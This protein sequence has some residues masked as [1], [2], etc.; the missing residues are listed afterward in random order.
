VSLLIGTS[1][2]QYDDWRGRFYPHGTPTA[3][4]LEHYAASFCTVEVNNTFYRLPAAS[5]FDGWA[6]RTP[7]DFRFVVKAS[8]YLTHQ[9]RLEDPGPSVDLLMDRAKGL[10]PKLGPVLL[11]LPP[12]LGVAGDRLDV[13]LA[14]FGRR[15]VRVAVEFRHDSWFCEEVYAVLRDHDAALCLTDRRSHIGPLVRTASWGYVRLHEG[16]AS[17]RPCYGRAALRSWV[18]RIS[19]LY[20]VG[21]DV[22][23]FTN[24]DHGGCAVRDARVLAG[25]AE[26]VG[27]KP[28]RVPKP[29]DTPVG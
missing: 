1:G 16:T 22:Y 5:T 27:L 12:T 21:A 28:T 20:G 9:R 26:D 19:D 23:V 13:T 6:A 8:R 2:W 7:D 29:E 4:W 10:G 24:N 14:A 11:Q 18:E 15:R 3:R 25:L 17:P